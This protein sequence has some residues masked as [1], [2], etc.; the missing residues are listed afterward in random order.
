MNQ[1]AE[2][3][4]E[5]LYA[6]ELLERVK[7]GIREENMPEISIAAGYGR[8]LTLLVRTSGAKRVLEIGALGGYSGI[9]LARGLPAD[10]RLVS[11][12]VNPDFAAVAKRH[13][14]LAGLDG[15]VEYRIG[16]AAE[17]LRELE[18]EGATFDFVF[19]DA[20]KGAYPLYLEAALRLAV[21]GT[22]IV[23]DNTLLKGKAADPA[24]DGPSVRAMRAFNAAIA[25]NPRLESTIL[26][27]YDGLAIARVKA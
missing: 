18:E 8:L 19:I 14:A 24:A 9:C 4:I 17:S 15:L 21:P 27:A 3:Y 7:R 26:P 1:A 11:L 5:S 6:D 22:L 23:G 12:E 16:D 2:E 13:L 20:D 10:G 25:G